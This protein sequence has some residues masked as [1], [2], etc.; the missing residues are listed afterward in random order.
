MD[1]AVRTKQGLIEGFSEGSGLAPVVKG[2]PLRGVSAGPAL[3]V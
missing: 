2:E 3:V 1:P